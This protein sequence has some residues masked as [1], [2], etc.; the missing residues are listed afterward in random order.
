M[1]YI[2]QR[3]ENRRVLVSTIIA[4]DVEEKE[5]VDTVVLRMISRRA[6]VAGFVTDTQLGLPNGPCTREVEGMIGW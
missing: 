3:K 5:V 1:V 2:A 6:T 4:R